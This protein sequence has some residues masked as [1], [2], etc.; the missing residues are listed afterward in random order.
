MGQLFSE[1]VY[2]W[3]PAQAEILVRSSVWS[4][5]T[6]NQ[7]YVSCQL[8][9]PSKPLTVSACF[10][11]RRKHWFWNRDYQGMFCPMSVR[12]ITSDMKVI[13]YLTGLAWTQ[14]E[15]N[16]WARGTRSTRKLQ[17]HAWNKR[18]SKR[19]F[20]LEIDLLHLDSV[21]KVAQEFLG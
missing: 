8:I 17:L 5:W 16:I 19:L 14:Y 11:S 10:C 7:L 13:F 4:E 2:N 6:N 12:V 3:N 18:R 9:L 21:K 15:S 1:R 20:F